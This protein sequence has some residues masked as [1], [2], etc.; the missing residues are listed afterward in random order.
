[1]H[2]TRPVSP[3][4]FCA[5]YASS[6]IVAYDGNRRDCEWTSRP[7][8]SVQS[9]CRFIR[10]ARGAA[11]PRNSRRPTGRPIRGTACAIRRDE[12]CLVAPD[13]RIALDAVVNLFC[14]FSTCVRVGDLA[15][16][17]RPCGGTHGMTARLCG[18]R[19]SSSLSGDIHSIRVLTDIAFSFV[20]LATFL[21]LGQDYAPAIKATST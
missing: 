10:V 21:I 20:S 18:K 8:A 2:R 1:M 15:K 19:I 5:R 3:E 13:K 7:L 17:L 9:T 11:R 16:R 12:T 14:E 6:V 4:S